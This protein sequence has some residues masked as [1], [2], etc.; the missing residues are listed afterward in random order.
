MNHL[1]QFKSYVRNTE[2][3]LLDS[4][5]NLNKTHNK[6]VFAALNGEPSRELRRL[7]NLNTQKSSG[8][9]FTGKELAKQT[10]KIPFNNYSNKLTILDPA[11]GAGDL[12]VAYAARL[13]LGNDLKTTLTNWGKQIRGYDIYPELVHL[14]KIRLA[15]LAILRGLPVNKE[16]PCLLSNTFPFIQTGNFLSITN[17]PKEKKH[18]LINPPFTMMK[19][20]NGCTWACGK[21]S[22]AA[23]FIEKCLTSNPSGSHISAILPDVLRTGSRYEKWRKLISSLAKITKIEVVGQ[24]DKLTDIDVFILHL[25]VKKDKGNKRKGFWALPRIK[26]KKRVKDLFDVNVGAV[27][28]HRDIKKG[29]KCRYI[30]ARELPKDGIVKRFKNY[31][32]FSGKLFSPPFVVIRRTSRPDEKKRIISTIIAGKKKVAAENH[33]I[34]LTPYNKLLSECKKLT[35]SLKCDKTTKWLDKRI[36]CRHLTVTALKELPLWNGYYKY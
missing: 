9:F 35:N 26:S 27:V 36:R 21:V 7:V 23:V 19:A 12:L 22:T 13:P 28:P 20:P 33:L 6:Q 4:F 24:F 3:L 5:R 30:F 11:C 32:K 16:N 29:L 31:R 10:C 18:I 34:V 14:T 25:T 15:L 8:I 2:T 1:N 17:E